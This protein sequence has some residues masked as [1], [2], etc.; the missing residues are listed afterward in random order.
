MVRL[1]PIGLVLINL[2]LV[3]PAL[4]VDTAVPGNRMLAELAARQIR[5]LSSSA[6]PE[7]VRAHIEYF[8]S[9]G[10]RVPGYEGSDAAYQHVLSQFRALRLRDVRTDTF[11]VGV[12][13]DAADGEIVV[14]GTMGRKLRAWCLWP[15][16]V[17]T[18]T[19]RQ[20]GI[21]GPL[22][23][24]GDGSWQD[25]DG[26]KLDGSIVLMD[27]GSD[28]RWLRA[29]S[30]G[31]RAI[32][33]AGND[34]TGPDQASGKFLPVPADVPRFWVDGESA[35]VMLER[36]DEER[37]K[38][39]T[40][41]ARVEARMDWQSVPAYNV[42][43]WVQGIDDD[44]PEGT[45]DRP[46]KW[47]DQTILLHAH[48]DATSVVPALAPGA[49]SAASITAL[50]EIARVLTWHKPDHT[51]LF[52]ATSGHF[53]AQQGIQDFLLRHGPDTKD[54][55]DRIDFDL[56]LSLDLSSGQSGTIGVATGPSAERMTPQSRRLLRA[57]TKVFDD[58]LRYVDGTGFGDTAGM[59]H[60][61][62]LADVEAARS[63]Y[64]ALSLITAGV[65]R[66]WL[67]TPFDTP[68][69]V[70]YES[71]ATQIHTLTALVMWAS[72][73]PLLLADR[74]S[75]STA[76]DRSVDGQLFK[77]LDG[78]MHPAAGAWVVSRP[79]GP[80]SVGGVR[81]STVTS[82][83]DY[84]KYHFSS[85]DEGTTVTAYTIDQASGAIAG[86]LD[87][88]ADTPV[89][90]GSESL[91]LLEAENTAVPV[92]A[93]SAVARS[94][95]GASGLP[96]GMDVFAAA[97]GAG[98][99]I[100]HA[101]PKSSVQLALQAPTGGYGHVVR[102][103]PLEAL[104]QPLD[105]S[106]AP[107]S[108]TQVGLDVSH[109]RLLQP[110]LVMAQ[111]MWLYDTD[112]LRRWGSLGMRDR[113]LE[114]QQERARQALLDTRG[115]VEARR[116]SLYHTTLQAAWHVQAA[117]H[118]R[119]EI[120][121]RGA[122][123]SVVLQLAL[124]LPLACVSVLA[125]LASGLRIAI[126]VVVCAVAGTLIQCIHPARALMPEASWTDPVLVISAAAGV[127]LA[128]LLSRTWPPRVRVGLGRAAIL[129]G[130]LAVVQA[131]AMSGS[132][133]HWLD[134]PARAVVVV[135]AGTLAV[136]TA[137][138]RLP[139][140]ISAGG[141]PAVLAYAVGPVAVATVL[142][143]ATGQLMLGVLT[144]QGVLPA[145]EIHLASW[146]AA[147]AA[148][149]VLLATGGMAVFTAGRA[150]PAELTKQPR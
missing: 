144:R 81:T 43:G 78:L 13:I 117:V 44:M 74:G 70:D 40:P 132:A 76:T 118:T 19:T 98:L 135:V 53:T 82:A 87:R 64:N 6:T 121:R 145:Q 57:V 91:L 65:D 129:T 63:G 80:G 4:A 51:L 136:V 143:A 49:E 107:V 11:H 60:T 106:E 14:N 1:A 35:D 71:V 50:L 116:Y 58:S 128:A 84:G 149:V 34:D 26:K 83:D 10:S 2:C 85:S 36:I 33:F 5:F 124:L 12:P 86:T 99:S 109:R 30:L 62:L 15:N 69:R 25:L 139:T 102:G 90:F 48:Y 47:K 100:V 67:D 46:Q 32:I 133:A 147:A 17:R 122:T 75:H 24:A 88:T 126:T 103:L 94:A 39:T 8:V 52:V 27:F 20:G 114:V 42:Y 96:W 72:K 3:A 131:G 23:H 101:P 138:C 79:P 54:P 37:R 95:D 108:Q 29:A 120:L 41:R 68:D 31:A 141:W 130:L 66:P 111:D 93:R 150:R 134:E 119:V 55:A 59:A 7:Q 140:Q 148:A 113:T 21:I 9:L 125:G 18:P 38:G 104:N 123:A 45:R 22:V 97:T 16:G 92:A 28:D 89:I 56:M 146:G 77:H 115:H 73:D 112:Q 61:V 142:S 105:I 137:V 127:I 110:A